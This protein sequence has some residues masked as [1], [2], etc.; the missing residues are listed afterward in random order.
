MGKNLLTPLGLDID[1][2]LNAFI[3]SGA[4]LS[5][6]GGTY[7]TTS[8]DT[9]GMCPCDGRAISR[10]TYA[11]LYAAIGT[12]WGTGDGTTTFNVPNL[13][14]GVTFLAGANANSN[15]NT[16]AG[17]SSHSH[18]IATAATSTSGNST[19]DHT[20]SWGG[21]T[22][23]SGNQYH[24]HYLGAFFMNNSSGP[25]PTVFKTD[26]GTSAAAI[27]HVHSGYVPGLGWGLNYGD[28]AHNTGGN[29]DAA[30]GTGHSHTMSATSTVGNATSYPA[31]VTAL[32]YIK[33]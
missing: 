31:Y 28:H 30:S 14:T 6:G 8:I 22:N 25:S 2:S 4:I 13:N 23:N 12:T 26:G 5:Y 1:S 29:M 19:I 27:N 16:T 10:T 32:H 20:H 11:A 24:D 18:T 15:L 7:S 21:A 17:A 33:L 3:P 9:L